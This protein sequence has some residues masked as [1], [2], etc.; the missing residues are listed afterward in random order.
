MAKLAD[1]ADLKSVLFSC[2][3]DSHQEYQRGVAQL[4]SAAALE[5]DGRRFK[6]CHPDFAPVTELGYVL[7]SE[8]RFCR[9]KSCQGHYAL[10]AE[11][12]TH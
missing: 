7:E 3:F 4:G 1:A 2:G 10:V 6:S 11:R 5:A 12:N 9:F 8:S